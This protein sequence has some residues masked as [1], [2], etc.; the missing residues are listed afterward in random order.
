MTA[1]KP[2]LTNYSCNYHTLNF[3][4]LPVVVVID[5]LPEDLR[6]SS[7]FKEVGYRISAA[8]GY[9]THYY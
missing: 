8:I 6:M 9:D 7:S 1:L 5:F 4:P 2:A 3:S